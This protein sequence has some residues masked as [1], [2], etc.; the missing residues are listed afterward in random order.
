M[1]S[2]IIYMAVMIASLGAT[3]A[4]AWNCALPQNQQST[5]PH[6]ECYIA[7]KPVSTGSA[8]NASAAAI[9]A[10]N[11]AAYAT[12]Q[13]GK[14]GNGEASVGDVAAAGGDANQHQGQHQQ[15]NATADASNKGNNIST[16]SNTYVPP[17]IAPTILPSMIISGCGIGATAGGGTPKGN[18]A[19][20]IE[21]TSDEC[22]TLQMA[23][24]DYAMGDYQTGCELLHSNKTHQNAAKRGAKIADC[25]L[26]VPRSVERI[27]YRDVNT[28]PSESDIQI[29][30]DAA[31]KEHDLINGVKSDCRKIKAIQ[32]RT[33]RKSA[34]VCTAWTKV[35]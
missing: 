28:G 4:N 29:R 31:I 24:A 6:G 7:P 17:N 8:S 2:I 3:T 21:F 22:Y 25:A 18:G 33:K 35:K 26:L 15:Q 20:G 5:N 32:H 10:A 19:F 34:S 12:A 30:I 16:T 27:V 13:G 9:A 23:Y 1:R 11:A 14:G